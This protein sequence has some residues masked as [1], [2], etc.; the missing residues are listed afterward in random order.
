MTPL[1]STLQSFSSKLRIL[2][3]I[4]EVCSL[5]FVLNQ[6]Y[7]TRM[8]LKFLDG[9]AFRPSHLLHFMHKFC[10]ILLN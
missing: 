4:S 2:A 7:V 6:D 8:T 3:N 5:Q 1:G 9:H 10:Y